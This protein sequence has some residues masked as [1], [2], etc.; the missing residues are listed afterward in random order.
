M[1]N[2]HYRIVNTL[3][4]EQLNPE[5]VAINPQHTVPTLV[6]DGKAIWDS[7]VI[8][9]YLVSKYGKDD[10][11][12]PK[13]LYARA[14]VDQ[15]LHFDNGVLFPRF[16]ALV[17][18]VFFDNKTEWDPE[19]VKQIEE[20][21]Q[22]LEIFLG[23]N[24]YLAGKQLTIADFSIIATVTSIVSNEFFDLGSYPRIKAWIER[25][26]QLPYYAEVNKEPIERGSQMFKAKLEANKAGK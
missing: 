1:K 21:F 19:A 23:D 12:Y 11:L 24:H 7:H 25:L 3:A 13:D 9:P 8:N 5:F 6:D 2:F 10:S 15:R 14:V 4:K 17:R 20:A 22:F 26:E 16:G 18:P